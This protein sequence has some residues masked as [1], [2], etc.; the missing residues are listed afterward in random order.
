[1]SMLRFELLELQKLQ[2]PSKGIK[3]GECADNRLDFRPTSDDFW[4]EITGFD[5]NRDL[6][7]KVRSLEPAVG[8]EA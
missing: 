4:I 7:V 5:V 8:G 6:I 2:R 3:E 1:M